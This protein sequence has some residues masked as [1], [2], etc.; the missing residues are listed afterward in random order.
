MLVRTLVSSEKRVYDFYI[1]GRQSAALAAAVR[2]GL[3]AALDGPP[4]EPAELAVRLGIRERPLAQLCRV[5]R[6]MGLLERRA[7]RLALSADAAACL[8]PGR[9][10]ALV[11]LIDL[12]VENFLSPALV[13]EAIRRDAPA[14]YGERDP[15]RAHAESAERARA[16]TRAMHD[17][18][19]GPGEALA[20]A[21]DFA[22][23]GR[24]LD[25]G[26]GSGALA[27][28]LA[29]TWPLL[30]CVLFDLP[31]VCALARE[32]IEAAG[33]SDRIT[34]RG[35]DF[36]ADPLP[37]DFDAL[38]LSQILHDWPPERGA[39]LLERA[40]TALRP[41][42]LVLIH[43]KLVDDA[44]LTPLANALVD[45]DMLVWT[46]GQQYTPAALRA[47]L[48]AA[49]FRGVE[50]RATSGYWSVTLARA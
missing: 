2:L 8:V 24:L 31:G 20:R 25:L 22:R 46:E 13:L 49:G 39:R 6:A 33:L 28:A 10:G 34:T 12:E 16:F 3:F 27:I 40:R 44:G 1:A 43:E 35:G 17:I 29:T 15:W 36:F 9:P 19:A 11:G 38:L 45:L 23:G 21:V 47:L 37:G 26:G 30:E 48:E 41:G 14:V 42:G 32:Y 4:L 18:S 7:T 5:L 50:T